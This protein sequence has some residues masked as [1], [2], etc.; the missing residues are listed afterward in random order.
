FI[1]VRNESELPNIAALNGTRIPLSIIEKHADKI[2]R[3][4]KVVLYCKSGRRSAE[5]IRVLTEK[6]RFDNLLNLK[7]G[8]DAWLQYQSLKP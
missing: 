4:Q 3:E 7:G 5:A 6:Y 8:V 2:D 1:D